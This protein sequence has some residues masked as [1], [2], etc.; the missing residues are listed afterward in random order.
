MLVSVVMPVYNARNTVGRAMKAVLS[1]CYD[2]LELLVVDDGSTDDSLEIIRSIG[3]V[4]PRVK[5]I[6]LR[7]NGGVANA[8]NSALA[9]ASGEFIAFCDADDFWLKDKLQIQLQ[10][11]EMNAAT[12]SHSWYWRVNAVTAD[13]RLCKFPLLISYGDMLNRN[14]ICNSSGIYNRN[15]LGVFYQ[16]EI[17][18]EDYDMWLRIIKKAGASVCCGEPLLQYSVS[19]DSLSANKIKSTIG[20]IR[21]QRRQGQSYIAVLWGLLLNVKSRLINK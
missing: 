15:V 12:V 7:A 18:H 4:D 16:D 10:L 8:R 1:Q 3:D 5:A 17:Y 9:L 13:S 19:S 20:M 14:Y 6:A 2:N 21:I 11:M